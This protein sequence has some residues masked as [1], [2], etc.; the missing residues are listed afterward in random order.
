MGAVR[1]GIEAPTQLPSRLDDC[2]AFLAG[3]ES[4]PFVLWNCLNRLAGDR[5]VKECA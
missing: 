5:N 2:F 4:D 3:S 1:L